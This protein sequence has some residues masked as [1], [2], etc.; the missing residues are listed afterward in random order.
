MTKM[1]E[2][3]SWILQNFIQ[4]V[5]PIMAFFLFLLEKEI[6]GRNIFTDIISVSAAYINSW[7]V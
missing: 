4:T 2:N 3:F 7:L 5:L 6:G 1:L